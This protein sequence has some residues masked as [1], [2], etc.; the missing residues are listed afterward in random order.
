[1][2]SILLLSC[3]STVIRT[4]DCYKYLPEGQEGSENN[5]LIHIPTII[6][7]NY[8][9]KTIII[10]SNNISDALIIK[11]FFKKNSNSKLKKSQSFL[12]YDKSQNVSGTMEINKDGC[13][14]VLKDSKWYLNHIIQSK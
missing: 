7:F 4:Y 6:K 1:M 14:L 8:N 13:L 9:S 10:E 12:V 2:F 3:S 5:I 11:S